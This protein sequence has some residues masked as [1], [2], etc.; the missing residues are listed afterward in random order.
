[1]WAKGFKG[2][3]VKVA[4]FDTGIAKNHKSFNHIEDRSNWVGQ[5]IVMP[6]GM[7]ILRVYYSIL[8]IL[9]EEV[10]LGG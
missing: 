3:H 5:A 7:E 10:V 1:M 8:R 2:A 6:V 9:L 4:V